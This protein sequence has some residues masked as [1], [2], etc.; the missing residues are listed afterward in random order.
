MI[1]IHD[2]VRKNIQNLKPYSSARDEYAGNI[3]IFLDANENSIG[4]TAAKLL[5]RYPDPRHQKRI[6]SS[7]PHPPMV[8][9]KYVQQ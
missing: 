9:M 8:C 7:L 2:L 3:G 5:N 4:S 6:R 1:N